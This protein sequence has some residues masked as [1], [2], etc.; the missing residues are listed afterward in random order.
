MPSKI[1]KRKGVKRTT[2]KKV[3]K[4]PIKRKKSVKKVNKKKGGSRKIMYG[5]AQ[6]ESDLRALEKMIGGFEGGSSC[7]SDNNFKGDDGLN[8]GAGPRLHKLD[9]RFTLHTVEGRDAKEILAKRGKDTGKY[10]ITTEQ[11]PQ[12]AARK[13]Y[14]SMLKKLEIEHDGGVKSEMYFT[15]RLTHDKYDPETKKWHRVPKDKQKVYGPYDGIARKKENPNEWQRERQIKYD[16]FISKRITKEMAKKNT[17]FN[18]R[19]NNANKGG[20]RFFE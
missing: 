17:R 16:Y 12:V 13:A 6:L 15:I 3:V 11:S 18:L 10:I 20:W 8:G 19:K 14:K 7:Q 5:A 1:I 9:R 2:K 4:K